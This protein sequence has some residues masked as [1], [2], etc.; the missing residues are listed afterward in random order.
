MISIIEKCVYMCG[1]VGAMCV[2]TVGHVQAEDP[3]K[4]LTDNDY[5]AVLH[6]TT[7]RCKVQS[8]SALTLYL[9]QILTLLYHKL[10]L[11]VI[12]CYRLSIATKNTRASGS[13]AC[14]SLLRR[15]PPVYQ[16]SRKRSSLQH[17]IYD[18]LFAQDY[19]V[20]D[21]SS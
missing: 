17:M 7:P 3:L 5:K 21:A 11:Q 10:L 1:P 8:I 12:N 2:S 16:L 14:K 13:F 18:D 6:H 20:I 15:S 9:V 4:T 19:W